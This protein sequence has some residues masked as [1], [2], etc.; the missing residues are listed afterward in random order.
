MQQQQQQHKTLNKRFAAKEYDAANTEKQEQA[1]AKN[2]DE[3]YHFKDGV[4]D[5]DSSSR[6]SHPVSESSG[7]TPGSGSSSTN[8][9]AYVSRMNDEINKRFRFKLCG[10]T[11]LDVAAISFAR[12]IFVLTLLGASAGLAVA[13]YKKMRGEEADTFELEVS[14]QKE[15]M[16]DYIM[17]YYTNFAF[18]L[19]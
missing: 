17:L 11:W 18:C 2:D 19:V 9:G 1:K 7:D 8:K 10:I 14:K 5:D 6:N 4:S 13:V 3:N 15:R 12:W 16:G